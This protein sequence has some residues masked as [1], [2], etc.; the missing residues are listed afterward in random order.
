MFGFIFG[1]IPLLVTGRR[2]WVGQATAALIALGVW[3]TTVVLCVLLERG[4]HAGP[5]ETLLRTA[6]ARSEHKRTTPPPPPAVWPGTQP[7]GW[8]MMQMGVQPGAPVPMQPGVPPVGQPGAQPGVPPVGQ[9]G[10]QPGMPA[11]GHP[12]VQPGSQPTA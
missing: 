6:V 12:G 4:G 8:P 7:G 11:V 10:V 3:L 2:M 9:P 1:V 5:F